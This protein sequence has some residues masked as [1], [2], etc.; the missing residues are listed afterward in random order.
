MSPEA[1][2]LIKQR[3]AID[4]KVAVAAFPR[5]AA[6]AIE[7]RG[8]GI[9]SGTILKVFEIASAELLERALNAW[10]VCRRI[11][12]ADEALPS[13]ESRVQVIELVRHLVGDQSDDVERIYGQRAATMQGQW[14]SIADARMRAVELATSEI[15]IDFLSRRRRAIPLGDALRLPRYTAVLEHWARA[16]EH[17]Q[18]SP[19]N[20][21]AAIREGANAIESLARIAC[22]GETSTLGESLKRL[23]STRV[24]D[25]GFDKMVEGIYT[26]RNASPGLGHGAPVAPTHREVD[27]QVMKPMIEGAL[28][29]L[30]SVDVV[31]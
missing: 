17:A 2:A 21:S 25:P 27:W 20:V 5:K 16:L 19:P 26:F 28:T 14:P 7:G 4:L 31:P 15:D 18:E 9:S 30:V 24:L 23:R 22:N 29:L 12:D 1:L 3:L 10:S 6:Q 11:L 8:M 13:E